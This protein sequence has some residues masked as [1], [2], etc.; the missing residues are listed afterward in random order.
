MT[1]REKMLWYDRKGLIRRSL[2][3]FLR[4]RGMTL[5]GGRLLF[6]VEV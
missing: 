3:V 2:D 1:G 5:L 4:K 6:A